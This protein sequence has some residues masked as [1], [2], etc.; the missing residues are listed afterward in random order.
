MKELD[1]ID[2]RV[3]D[4]NKCG[5]NVEKFLNAKTVYLGENN[6]IVIIGEAPANNGWRKSKMLWRDTSGKVLPSGVILQK[7]FK[8]IDR[9]IFKTTFIEAIKCYPKD[10]KY[11]KGCSNNCKQIMLDQL[12]ILKPKIIIPLGEAATRMIIKDDFKRFKDVVGRVY[13]VDDYKIIPIYHPS[14]VSPMSYKGNE[15]IFAKIKD[16]L[17]DA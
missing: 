15:P 3:M 7:L 1:A 14:P 5:E 9:D 6:D 8:I 10:R 11:I 17:K 12:A 16:I 4:C 13:E 2:K